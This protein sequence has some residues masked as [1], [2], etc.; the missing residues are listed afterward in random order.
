MTWAEITAVAAL[1]VSIIS[2]A[3]AFFAPIR[4]ERLK[5]ETTQRERELNCFSILMSER[6]RWGSPNMLAALNAVKVIFRDNHDVLD[7]WFICYSK[8]GTAEGSLDHYNDLLAEIGRHVGLPMRREDLDNF[9]TNPIEQR[10][11]AIRQAQVHRAFAELSVNSVA[12]IP[13][14]IN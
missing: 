5:R 8:V 3:F 14:G 7:R 9:F 4:A 11:T 2:A 13:A 1:V 10:E 12:S 6:G